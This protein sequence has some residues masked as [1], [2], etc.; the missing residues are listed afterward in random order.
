MHRGGEPERNQVGE[1]PGL[2][3]SG[4]A[5]LAESGRVREDLREREIRGLARRRFQTGE[6]GQILRDGIADHE[7]AFVLQHQNRDAGD[8]LGHGGDPE[9]RVGRHRALRRGIRETVGFQVQDSALRDD[10]SDR[11]PDF[12]LR[13]HS[14][15]RCADA[16]DFR[17]LSGGSQRGE[18]S[19]D[20]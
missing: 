14:L 3:R 12:L 16:R 2:L 8:R 20:N 4:A 1:R 11:T 6:L 17:I 15:H 10:D 9:Q 18:E 5:R 7:L 19:K 13:D